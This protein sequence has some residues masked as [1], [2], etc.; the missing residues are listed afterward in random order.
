M[1]LL[2]FSVF[3]LNKSNLQNLKLR[4]PTY[5]F[6]G[7]INLICYNIAHFILQLSA[8]FLNGPMQ[9][10]NKIPVYTQFEV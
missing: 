5:Q 10:H 4:Y 9:F 1:I 3:W 7:S 2:F 8:V 6:Q